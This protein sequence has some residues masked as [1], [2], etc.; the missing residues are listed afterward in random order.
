[1]L[2]EALRRCIETYLIKV[3][4]FKAVNCREPVPVC[5]LN[6]VISLCRLFDAFFHLEG[7]AEMSGFTQKLVEM[8][9]QFCLIWSVC[10]SVDEDGRKKIDNCIREIVGTFPNKDTV[11]EYYVDTN[12]GAWAHWEEKLKGKWKY[13]PSIPF[14]KLSVPTVDTVRYQFLCTALIKR[15]KPVLMVGAVGT[16]KTLVIESTLANF[17][18]QEYSILTVTMSAQSRLEKH[19]KG[20]F[21]PIGGK[22]LIT[23]MDDLNMPAKDEYGYQPPLELMRQWLEYGFWFDRNKRIIQYIKGMFLVSAM[24]PPGGGRMVIS[25]RLQSRFNLINMTFP[26][27]S[28][29]KR[30]FGSMISQKLQNFEEEVKVLSDTLTQGTID[31]YQAIVLRFLPTPTRIHYLFNLRDISR[32]FQGLLRA[33]KN[34]HDTKASIIR[35]WM[36]ECYRVF[37]DRLIDQKDLQAFSDVLSEKLGVVFEQTFNNLCPNKAIPLFGDFMNPQKIY[38]QLV[39]AENV[40]TFMLEQLQVYNDTPKIVSMDLVLFRDAVEHISRIV[41]V[42]RQPHGNMLLIGINGSGRQSLTRLASFLCDYVVFQIEVSDRYGKHE[43]REDMKKLY[44]QTGVLN[45]PTVFLFSDVQAAEKSFFEDVNCILSSGEV[46]NLYRNDELEEMK[47]VLSHELNKEGL[48]DSI[49]SAYSFLIDRVRANLHVVLCMSPL[50]DEFRNSIRMFPALVNNT[51]IDWFHEWPAEALLE[52]ADKYI[53]DM[54]LGNT[55]A[56]RKQFRLQESKASLSQMFMLVHKSVAEYSTK[57]F[58][59]IRRFNCVSPTNYLE[60]VTGYKELIFE[61]AKELTDDRDKLRSGLSK[62]DETREKVEK[63]SVDLEDAK[64]MVAACQKECEEFLKTLVQQKREADEQQ[65][66]VAIKS[67]R[68]KEEEIKCQALADVAQADLD[69]AM[70]ALDEANKALESLNK[71][72]MTEIKSYGRPPVLVEKV[73]EAVMILR[74]SDQNFLKQLMNYDKDNITDRILRKIG[75]YVAQSDFH[76]DIIGGVSAAAK[77][78]CMWVRAMEMYGR[79]YRVVE[80]KRIKLNAA[81][82]VLA[83]KREALAEAKAKL[84]EVEAKLLELKLSYDEKLAQKEELRRKADLTELMLD[85]AQRLMSGLH[86]ERV[87]WEEKVESLEENMGHLIGDVLIAAAFLSYLGPFLTT[88]RDEILLYWK[89]QI[90]KLKIPCAYR[91]NFCTFMTKPTQL[92]EWNIQGLPR[93]EFSTE[94]GIIVTRCQRWPFLIDPQGQGSRWIKNMEGD[95]GLK[96]IDIRQPKYLS[97]VELAIQCGLP[98]LLTNVLETLDPSLNPLFN[99]SFIK[100][101]GATYIKFGSHEIEYNE[102]FRFYLTT[103]LGN[104]HLSPQVLIKVAAVNFAVMS[105]GLEAQLLGVVVRKERPELEEQK[106]NL[107]CSIAAGKKKLDEC[108]DEILRLL[109]ETKGSLLDDAQLVDT[110]QLSKMISIEVTESVAVSEQMEVKI[111]AARECYRPCAEQASILFFILN[112]LGNIDPMY[113]FSLDTYNDLFSLSIEKSQ[114]AIKLDERITN[115]NEYHLY[116]VYKHVCRGL[117]EKHKLIFSFQMCIKLLEHARRLNMD[118]YNF[119]LRGGVVIDRENQMDNPCT[120]WLSDESW[121]NITELDK[122]TNFH[123]IITSFEQYSRDWYLWYISSEPENTSLPGEWDKA[124]NE[125][126]RMLVVRSLRPDRVS[127]CATAFIINNMG[128]KFTEPPIL[129][130]MSIVD[131]SSTRTPLIFIVSPG[132]DPRASL[133]QIAESC[134]MAA[135]FNTLS[136][137]QGQASVATRLLQTAVTEG[138]WVFLANCHLSMSWMPSL[139]QLVDQLQVEQCHPNFRLWL[140]SLPH[141]DFPISVLQA[142]VKM[143][144]EHPKGLKAGMKRLY[145]LITEQQFQRCHKLEKYKKLLFALCFFHTILLERKK[146][147]MLGW[148]IMYEFNDSDFEVDLWSCTFDKFYLLSSMISV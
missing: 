7:G 96:V 61:K 129:D 109:N 46:A 66:S 42:I 5:E 111:D 48:E 30:I 19:T 139:S 51:A 68:I 56:D 49:H 110:L 126:Q 65:K 136:L 89:K 39:S 124:C 59:E 77:S 82:A 144:T 93:D 87:R 135:Q 78:L 146:F 116:A 117:F 53:S 36:H 80:P 147:K 28:Q 22:K 11:Y 140:S 20:V 58:Q 76:P 44:S 21:V 1:G 75:G 13:K 38:E 107:V 79:I 97:E 3:M 45:K 143:T 6:G 137:G 2:V 106:D 85:R 14:Y 90:D 125:L 119:F 100:A 37:S 145:S 113:Q 127:F 34:Y 35:L 148:N 52:V 102:D 142:G 94:N 63:M 99:K 18:K 118:E 74:G 16:G 54:V 141:P 123:G 50:E 29:I 25:N 138:R 101:E 72:D 134:G 32:V 122:L 69:E 131:E 67:E 108:E 95:F 98:V 92:R 112:D 91:F 132:S 103:K 26:Q 128:Q 105:K 73:M 8:W 114:R 64:I 40:K 133:Q 9:F 115:L 4:E 55:Q 31:M 15:L 47:N 121:D 17:D 70:P 120:T 88:F 24:G 57:M 43:F 130:M 23:F 83:Q 27:D 12:T 33:N 62:I 81:L 86:S 104:P 60:L 10:A 84:A 41:R 71:R